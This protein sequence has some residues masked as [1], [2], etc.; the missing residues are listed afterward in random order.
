MKQ[1]IHAVGMLL[2]L[3]WVSSY[4]T[5]LCLIA[6]LAS[7]PEFLGL[8][9]IWVPIFMGIGIGAHIAADQCADYVAAQT[10]KDWPKP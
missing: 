6:L 10:V 8:A 4:A 9:C 7:E 2:T 3:V 5:L 1:L